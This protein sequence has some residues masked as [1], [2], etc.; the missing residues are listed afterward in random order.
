MMKALVTGANGFIGSFLVQA[1]LHKQYQVRC[2]ILN[3]EPLQWLTGLDVEICYGD[4]CRPETLGEAVAGVDYIYHLAAVKTTWDEA[5]YFR[6][7]FQGTKNLLDAV[8]HHTTAVRRF[9]YVSSQA[10]AGPSLNGRPLT[11]D[12]VCH[13]LTAYGK[14]KRAAEEYVYEHHSH[15]PVTILRPSLVYGPRNVETKLLYDLTRWGVVPHIHHHDQYFN[16]THVRDVV[17]GL[18]LAA[19]HERGAGQIFFITSSEQYTWPEILTRAVRLRNK[20]PWRLPIPWAGIK[21]TADVVKSYRKLRGQPFSLID[22]KM[23]ELRQKHWLCSGQKAKRELGFEP[24]IRLDEGITET[25]R[26]YES[27]KR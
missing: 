26:W 6:I 1:L 24:K 21:F 16:L 17:E 15:V 10:A 11:E 13:P 7:N 8:L 14:S 22:D 20:R 19:E 4:V 12:D 2:F 9:V 18:I 25:L 27:V 23:N 5:A 3:G